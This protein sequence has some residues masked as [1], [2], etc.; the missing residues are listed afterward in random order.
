MQRKPMLKNVEVSQNMHVD[1]HL[2]ADTRQN[3]SVI[4]IFRR[5]MYK[6]YF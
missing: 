2:I 1:N 6:K 5:D 3:I 4:A